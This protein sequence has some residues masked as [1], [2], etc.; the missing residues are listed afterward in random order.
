MKLVTVAQMGDLERRSEAGG[1]ATDALMERAGLCVARTAWESFGGSGPQAVVVV[2]V[3]PGNNGADGLVA[4]RHL[5]RWGAAV[6]AY[7]CAGRLR[8]GERLRRCQEAGVEVLSARGD[9][10]GTYLESLL[11]HA[12]LVVD[13]VLGTGQSRPIEGAVRQA[14]R[15]VNAERSRRG[16]RV[17]AV[18]LPSGVDADTGRADVSGVVSDV[19]VTL[20]CP[21]VGLFQFPGA[22]RV[23]RLTVADIGIPPE[24]LSDLPNEVVTAEWASGH[25][26]TRVADAHKGTFGRVM[27]L[28]GSP[29]YLGAPYLACMGAARVGAGYVTL[30][31]LPSIQAMIAAKITEPT[32]LLL[33]EAPTGSFTTRAAGILREALPRYDSLLVGPGLGGQPLTHV[34]LQ[35][36]LLDGESLP[37]P[38]VIDADGLN[39]LAASPGW[40]ERITRP[41][42][43]TPH[44][45]EMAR[46]LGVP[47]EDVEAHRLEMATEAAAR[48]DVTLLLKGAYTVVASPEGAGRVIPFANPA[49]A[50]AGTGD[51]LAGAIAGL[52][53][54]GMS[55]FDAASFGAFVHAAAGEIVASELGRA[56]VVATDVLSALPRALKAIAEGSFTGG[57]DELR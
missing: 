45:G 10:T 13:A 42:V 30:A 48:W 15:A 19:T 34:L 40:W 2:L 56:G 21:K 33:P 57:P 43:L 4:A 5:Q 16:L 6:T 54:Q 26:P 17:V 18:D 55:P 8:E 25:I 24:L 31:T 46:L 29:S 35:H 38:V 41:A 44:A 22:A 27:V 28:A 12:T 36:V 37:H 47:V 39:F 53:A 11:S 51:V 32:Y 14:F 7:L 49:L 3:G 23:G 1:V 52:L 9:P 50:T 20:G